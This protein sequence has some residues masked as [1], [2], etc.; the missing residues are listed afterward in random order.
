MMQKLRE[1]TLAYKPFF[2]Q[3]RKKKKLYFYKGIF[4]KQRRSVVVF[5]FHHA[6]KQFYGMMIDFFAE[7]V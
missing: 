2:F 7:K 1:Y 4:Q 5:D 3:C 6:I